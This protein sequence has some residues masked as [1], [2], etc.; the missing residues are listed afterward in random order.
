MDL[1]EKKGIDKRVFERRNGE[2]YDAMII[3]N[4]EIICKNLSFIS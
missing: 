2:G 3:S 1:K 4:L